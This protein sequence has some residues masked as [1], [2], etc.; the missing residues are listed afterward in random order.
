VLELFLFKIVIEKKDIWR[1]GG[2]RRE[3][4]KKKACSKV[5]FLTLLFTKY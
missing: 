2:K 1:E 3:R 4:E 5:V